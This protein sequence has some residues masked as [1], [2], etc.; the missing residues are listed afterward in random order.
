MIY[1]RPKG[2]QDLLPEEQPY[3]EHVRATV[4]KIAY[5][6]GFARIDLPLF[7]E[8]QLFTRGVGESTDIVEKEMYSFQDRG[9]RDLTLRPEFTAGVVR[10]YIEN[11]LRVAPKPVKLFSIGPAFRYEQPQAGRFRQFHQFNA[12]IL[13]SEEPLADLEVMLLAWDLY[14]AL[15]FEGLSFQL[16]STGCPRCRPGYVDRLVAYYHKHEDE[17][18]DDCHRRLETNPLRVLDCKEDRCQPVIAGAPKITEHLCDDCA[19]H[20]AELRS[21]LDDLERPYTLNHRLV[22]GLDYYTKTVFEVWAGG[23]GAQAAV[24][25]GGRYD[26]LV[27]L[28]GGQP[29]PAVGFAAGLERIVMVMKAQDVSVPALPAP[30]V[31]VAHL[32]ETARRRAVQLLVELRSAGVA[33]QIAVGGSL[34]SQLRTADKK[35]AHFTLIL[36]ENELA[37]G[38]VAVKDMTVRQGQQFVALH[39][40]ADWLREH[41]V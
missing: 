4:R 25:G 16:N 18:C 36:G 41:L 9:G 13:G 39:E 11:G 24:C 29:T 3:W 5:H 8:T 17:I 22:R 14:A 33:A 7:E 35:G 15:D 21:Y 10:A 6:Y 40:I 32:G 34:R 28:L 26:G 27:E 2:T 1:S 38:E 31:F 23:I 19:A 12:E 37:R 20:F 30:P